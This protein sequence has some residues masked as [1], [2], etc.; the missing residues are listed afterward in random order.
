MSELAPEY[1]EVVNLF[2]LCSPK[3]WKTVSTKDLIPSGYVL[4]GA[5]GIIGYYSEYTHENPT[6]M[7][8]CR[9]ATCGNIHISKPFAYI[10]GNAMALDNLKEEACHLPYFA[11]FL[12]SRGFEDVITGSAQPQITQEGLRKIEVPLAPLN[13]Q[14]RIADK[15]DQLLAR[16]DACRER[17]D[18]IPVFLKRFRQAVLAAA[19][20]G[21][22]TED[23]RESVGCASRTLTNPDTVEGARCA[24]YTIIPIRK[25]ITDIRYGTSK[26]CIYDLADGTPVLRIPNI[27]DN[28]RLDG[29]NLKFALFD[30]KERENLELQKGDIL[31]IR[32][33]GSVDLVGKAAVVDSAFEGYLYAGYL[34]RLR[35]DKTKIIP[36]YL[37]I[38]LSSPKT[39][40]YIEL[41]ARSTAGVNNINSEEIQAI[42]VA[43]PSLG[44][45]QEII[46]RVEKLFAF[47]DR[48][49]ARYRQAR[50]EVDRLAPALLA[51]AFR[52]ELVPQDPNDEPASALLERLRAERTTAATQPKPRKPRGASPARPA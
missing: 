9:G 23:W 10:N 20:S 21:Q 50:A 42:E 43:T 48:L 45:Q 6:V 24:P 11:Y 33:N 17:L 40:A 8:T 26:K 3:Q 49:E 25:L 37:W 2:E 18:R 46:R 35:P 38:F 5:N 4:Y 13:E 36:Q 51:K 41:I 47:A 34:I 1:W 39:R 16:V 32:S 19:T 27:A 12:R 29:A 22:L 28:G 15:L 44:E 52:G 30:K 14:K 7:I 31:I